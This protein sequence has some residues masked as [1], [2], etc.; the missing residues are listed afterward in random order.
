MSL[1]VVNLMR[2]ANPLGVSA[3]QIITISLI[4]G[5]T[6]PR[7][8]I[9]PALLP[10]IAACTYSIA[11]NAQHCMR[12]QW[13]SSFGG[14]ASAFLLIY[15]EVAL[16]S[17][18]S[19][20]ARGPNS[21][22][23]HEIGAHGSA[24]KEKSSSRKNSRKNS[25]SLKANPREGTVW[26]RFCF[27]FNGMISFRDID[28]PFEVK[29]VPHFSKADPKYVP[30]RPKFMIWA[31][32]RFLACYLVLDIIESQPPPPN[33][34]QIFSLDSIPVFR[35][36]N[37]ISIEEALTRTI[38]SLIFWTMV[39]ALLNAQHAFFAIVTV[40]LGLTVVK[41]WRPLMGSL[42]ETYTIRGFWG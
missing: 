35:R 29:N 10:L 19:Y 5:F 41:A 38:S 24:K 40:G 36:I 30:S 16:L 20:E 34:A 4:L 22:I 33:V 3:F 14:Y 7:S 8:I 9:R 26:N 32:L 23:L 17:R 12:S 15:I 11:L 2:N 18:W 21:P 1:D 42:S 39:Y 25:S 6:S 31:I 27:G 37:E 13:A 28:T